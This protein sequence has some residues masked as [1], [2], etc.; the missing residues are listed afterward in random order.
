VQRGGW[1]PEN[2][3]HYAPDPEQQQEIPEMN[4]RVLRINAA[5]IEREDADGIVAAHNEDRVVWVICNAGC[6]R[7]ALMLC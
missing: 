5:F 7:F 6:P 1:H 2:R 3:A 4:T